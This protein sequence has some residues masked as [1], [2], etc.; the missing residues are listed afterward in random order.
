MLALFPLGYVLVTLAPFYITPVVLVPAHAA[1]IPV[2]VAG[3]G[4]IFEQSNIQ[5]KKIRAKYIL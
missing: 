3:W 5:I 2:I 4:L 1:V